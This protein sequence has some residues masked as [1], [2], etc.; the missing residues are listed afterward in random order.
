MSISQTGN[1]LNITTPKRPPKIGS[2]REPFNSPYG[3][4]QQEAFQQR[5]TNP[6]VF[7]PGAPRI[8]F[9]QPIDLSAK[10]VSNDNL[11]RSTFGRIEDIRQRG[12]PDSTIYDELIN[13]ILNH[14]K[15][16][17][18]APSCETYEGAKRYAK[19]HGLRPPTEGMDINHDG[20]QDVVLYNKVGFP[21]MINGYY[22]TPSKAPFRQMYK[23]DNPTPM[24][25]IN[26][27]GFKG[28]M[29]DVWGVQGEFDEHGGRTVTHDKYDPPG[30]FADLRD[31]GWRLPPAPRKQLSFHQLCM[32]TLGDAFRTFTSDE[33]FN[34]RRYILS[35]L[36]RLT[37]LALEYI[38][39]VD[40][41][42]INANSTFKQS[43]I[44]AAEQ[45]GKHPWD[46]YQEEK[47]RHKAHFKAYTQDSQ[48][49]IIDVCAS[50]IIFK[51]VM[52]AIR[53]VPDF[54]NNEQ[55][56]TQEQYNE[57]VEAAKY[58]KTAKINLAQIRFDIKNTLEQLLNQAKQSLIDDIF[59]SHV[60]AVQGIPRSPA[61]EPQPEEGEE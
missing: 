45:T 18:F 61:Q 3:K 29:N 34:P 40:R 52:D 9:A 55:L 36:P 56:P 22:F 41:S 60:D 38:D 50:P 16:I 42:F 51:D 10:P 21:V 37:I 2:N 59:T 57:I 1:T 33:V 26:I 31:Q 47:K 4:Q 30:P 39:I 6:V 43:V 11:S 5:F 25:R 58:D 27:G 53:F 32:R 19:A 8:N 14:K 28:Y 20:I 46:V 17:K 44:A 48:Q 12:A 35:L 24:D 54:I 15:D 13:L 23:K 7:H 49:R